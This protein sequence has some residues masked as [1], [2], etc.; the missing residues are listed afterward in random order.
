M[1]LEN[2]HLRATAASYR[3]LGTTFILDGELERRRLVWT[4]DPLPKPLLDA[5][6]RSSTPNSI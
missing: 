5:W 3:S 6:Q 2:R 1:L 4:V